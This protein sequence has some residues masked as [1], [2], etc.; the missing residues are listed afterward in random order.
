VTFLLLIE[1]A[2]IHRQHDL[3]EQKYLYETCRALEDFNCRG[4]VNLNGQVVKVQL[5]RGQAAV[6]DSLLLIVGLDGFTL[7]AENV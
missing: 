3:K 4:K 6:K 1:R 7:V 5:P 2:T